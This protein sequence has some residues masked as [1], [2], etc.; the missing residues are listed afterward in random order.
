MMQRM[1]HDITLTVDGREIGYIDATDIDIGI[2]LEDDGVQ[3]DWPKSFSG[4]LTIENISPQF[5][6]LLGLTKKKSIKDKKKD[7]YLQ[8]LN[9]HL[10][11]GRY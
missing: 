7:G 2:E 3:T 8:G 6:R 9:K 11:R 4:E 5:R 1:S 10:K